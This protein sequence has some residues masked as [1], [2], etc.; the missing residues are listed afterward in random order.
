MFKVANYISQDNLQHTLWQFEEI[1]L[2]Q[3]PLP[4]DLKDYY[5]STYNVQIQ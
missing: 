5:G 3:G 4:T 1:V 2:H